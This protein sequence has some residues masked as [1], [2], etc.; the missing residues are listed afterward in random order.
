MNKNNKFTISLS[1]FRWILFLGVFPIEKAAVTLYT[2]S[3]VGYYFFLLLNIITLGLATLFFLNN[4]KNRQQLSLKYLIYFSL[5][6]FIYMI[7]S[8]MADEFSVTRILSLVC[9]LG[10]Y[11]FVIHGYS[12]VDD[13]F[14]DINKAL[15]LIIIVSLMLYLVGSNNVLYRENALQLTF[16]GIVPNRNNYSEISL[17]FIT[18]NF[19]LFKKKRM[20]LIPFIMTTILAIYTTIL[21]RS[22]TSIV[23]LLLLLLLL[24]FSKSK[25]V[26]KVCLSNI[27][28][29]GYA[30]IFLILVLL[31]NTNFGVM[32]YIAKIFEKSV[33]L[34]GRTNI[35]TASFQLLSEFPLFGYGYDTQI[36]LRNGVRENDPH[37]SIIY[38]L[39]TGGIFGLILFIS[40]LKPLFVN[41]HGDIDIKDSTYVYLRIFVFIW[42]IKGLVESVFSYTHFVFWV[43]IIAFDMMIYMSRWREKNGY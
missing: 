42:A 32:S 10:Y 36:L 34:T 8:V 6:I 29:I 9:L 28:L 38:I 17:F 37:N 3:E 5:L 11:L 25:Y 43:T 26:K 2:N 39:L 19:V 7:G 27:M 31:Q 16:K 41:K 40:M 22:A 30:I 18:T 13:F 23:C 35:W 1:A 12:S 24:V 15:L 33:T 20:K 21:T 4:R 14:C